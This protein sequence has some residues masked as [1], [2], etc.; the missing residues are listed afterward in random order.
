MPNKTQSAEVGLRNV[1]DQFIVNQGRG[2]EI[3]TNLAS[4]MGQIMAIN[5]EHVK[6]IETL[7]AD[8][9]ALSKTVEDLQEDVQ[10]RNDTEL[11][12]AILEKKNDVSK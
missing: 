5:R 2:Q 3:V 7:K 12:E 6:T 11:G 9:E 1:L 10:L 8:V 4:D